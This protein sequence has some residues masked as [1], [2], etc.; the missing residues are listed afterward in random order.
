MLSYARALLAYDAWANARVFDAAARLDDAA[1]RQSRWNSSILGALQHMCAAQAVW[2]ARWT[3]RQPRSRAAATLT[4]I[5]ETAAEQH[6]AV[7][8]FLDSLQERDWRSDIAY[9]DSKGVPHR[10]PLG[11][12]ITHAFNHGTHHRAEAGL[13]LAEAGST[14]GDLDLL[15]FAESY[16]GVAPLADPPAF[17][18]HARTLAAYDR[19]AKQ[20]VI[21][22]ALALPATALRAASPSR[23]RLLP[24]VQH[25]FGTMSF[26]YLG[27]FDLPPWDQA[28][29]EGLRQV[30]DRLSDAAEAY[31]DGMA[32]DGW[33]R[34]FERPLPDGSVQRAG[35][36][37]LVMTHF[38]NHGAHH[39]A[40]AGLLLAEAGASPGD[41]DY[42]FFVIESHAF[43]AG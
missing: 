21:D 3:H 39:R 43:N 15:F 36:L 31:I 17:A 41:M 9:A 26:A 5:R 2:L 20:K 29:R 23:E 22:A 30:S 12:L 10:V 4:D 11:H 24:L 18:E 35:P 1:L 32:P 34:P 14:P 16:G 19:W 38:F 25:S 40:E 37:W 27:G 8:L 13:M 33:N 6:A 7:A 42:V 28:T